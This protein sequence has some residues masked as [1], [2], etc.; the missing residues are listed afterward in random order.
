MK[1]ASWRDLGLALGLGCS[2]GCVAPEPEPTTQLASETVLGLE[3]LGT[4]RATPIDHFVE[5][6]VHEGHVY[7]A[8]SGFGIAVM[9]LE[10]DGGLT[11]TEAGSNPDNLPQEEWVRCTTLALHA[12][13]DTL[14]C[15]SD[16][17]IFNPDLLVYDVSV[18]GA[19]VL[20]ERILLE[21][22]T[23]RD[24]EVVGDTLVL[25]AFEDGLWSAELDPGGAPAPLEQRAE[26]NARLVASVGERIVLGV[27]DMQGPGT[28]LRVLDPQTFAELDR[29][30]LEG[31]LIGLNAD[32]SGASQVAV[33]QGSLGVAL[34]DLNGDT[35]ALNRT[36]EAPGVAT[37]AVISKADDLAIVVTLSGAFAQTFEGERLFGFGPESAGAYERTGNMLHAVLHE[38]ELLT[39]DWTWVERWAIEPE[40]EAANLD[41]P[42]GV[43]L[44]AGEPARWRMRN[45]GVVDLR[46]EFW[47]RG[48]HR[49]EFVVPAE[50]SE[51]YSLDADALAEHMPGDDV[52]LPLAVRIHDPAVAREGEP[53]AIS[54]FVIAQPEPGAETPPPPGELLPPVMLAATDYELFDLAGRG[55]PTRAVFFSPGCP[56]MWPELEDLSW[57]QVH[58]RDD[59][60]GGRPLF[61]TDT[62]ANTNNAAPWAALG[63]DFGLFG[64]EAPA[65][66]NDAN[67][68]RYGDDLYN[69]FVVHVIPGDALASDY[70]LDAEGR[71]RSVERTYRGPWSLVVPWDG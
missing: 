12:S 9:R 64:V 49:F 7:V 22:W 35:L 20:R 1:C 23:I 65:E 37:A 59:L 30:E 24:L 47:F 16:S 21:Q 14:Y 39:S 3:L 50:S 6:L 26:G 61:V 2:F 8:N 63:V 52:V 48:E 55:Q 54:S 56:L 28:Q 4:E 40:G 38:G 68:P 43:Y 31:P 15:A 41:F 60:L 45:P 46:V 51:I 13:S 66:V 57:Q 27:A 25:A 62:D 67:S 71:V 44:R 32:S 69:A 53:L 58:G 5:L 11:L 70:E 17:P 10:E 36:L 34:V 19:P 29:L 42:R 33:A 18:P